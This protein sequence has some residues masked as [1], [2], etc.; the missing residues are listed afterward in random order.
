VDRV[1]AHTSG[2]DGSWKVIGPPH[3]FRYCVL[4]KKVDAEDASGDEVE[5]IHSLRALQEKLFSSEAFRAWLA[6]ISRLCPTKYVS[7]ARRFRPG[8]DYTLA[9]GNDKEVRLDVVLDLTPGAL[10]EGEGRYGGWECY[11]APDEGDEDPAIYRSG[12]QKATTNGPT[13]QTDLD[14]S[15]EKESAEE[16]ILEEDE[17]AALLTKPPSFNQLLIVLRD[18]GVLHF[19]KYVSAHGQ[20]SRW[21]LSG[22]YDI[23]M[24][25]MEEAEDDALPVGEHVDEQTVDELVDEL[26]EDAL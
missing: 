6:L 2:L 13:Q 14:V 7:E 20:G 9:T 5:H 18:E 23:E 21:D 22:E 12:M 8:L 16:D 26:V 1:P 10:C 11:M 3:K 4:D 19:V 24:I 25:Q 17:E 15:D